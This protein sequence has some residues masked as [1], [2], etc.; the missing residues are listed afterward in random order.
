MLMW[1][2]VQ[3]AIIAKIIKIV[4]CFKPFEPSEN[5]NFHSQPVWIPSRA[6]K[7]PRRPKKAKNNQQ[8]SIEFH[9]KY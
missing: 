4:D 2:L 9:M 7:P 3:I 8:T 5:R 1:N 6:E